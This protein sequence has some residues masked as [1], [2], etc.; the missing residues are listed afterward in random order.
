MWVNVFPVYRI[1]IPVTTVKFCTKIATTVYE[2]ISIDSK[3]AIVISCGT[4]I[5]ITA[6][7]TFQNPAGLFAIYV[8]VHI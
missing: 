3:T 6:D 7:K 4:G 1:T 2:L 8:Y 5:I